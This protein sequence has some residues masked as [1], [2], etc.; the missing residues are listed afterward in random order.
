MPLLPDR[1]AGALLGIYIAD[2][3]AMPVHVRS[4]V[5]QQIKQQLTCQSCQCQSPPPQWYYDVRALQRDYPG[6]ITK[7][8]APR[9]HHPSSIMHISNTGGHGRGG[10]QGNVIGDVINH[11]KK[12]FWGVPGMH[13]HQGMV[14]GEN[15]LNA[16]VARVVTRCITRTN[17]AYN[18]DA[19]LEDYVSFM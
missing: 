14:A 17:G 11:G 3:L 13:Y 12:Q 10:Q 18:A 1:L 16:L 5:Q 15:T 9:R 4:W 2:A 6:G 19:F 7:Y 8:E